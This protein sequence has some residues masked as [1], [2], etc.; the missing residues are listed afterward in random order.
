MRIL[1]IVNVGVEA[2]GAEKSVRIIAEGLRARGHEAYVLATDHMFDDSLPRIAD[3]LI[4]AIRGGAVRRLTGFF[5]NARAH[6]ETRRVLR[7]FRPDCVHLHTIGEFSPSVLAATRS[8]PRV[9]TVHGPEDWTLELLRWNLASAA[10]GGPLT[11]ADRARL[12]YL[13]FLQR[14]AYLLWLRRVEL[15]IAPSEYF[16]A[17]VRRD[18]GGVP[19]RVLANGIEPLATATRTAPVDVAP[20]DG[21]HVL[22]AGRLTRVKGVHVLVDAIGRLREHGVQARLTIVGDGDERDAL[23]ARAA[24]LVEQ[25]AVEFL[26]W[27]DQ[28]FVTGLMARAA[29]VVIPSLW[30]EN[31]PTVA[32]EALQAGRPLIASRVGGLPELVGEDNGGL[33]PA[34]DPAALAEMLAGVLGDAARLERLGAG[35]L[36][37]AAAY[38]VEPFIDRVIECYRELC[39]SGRRG[40]P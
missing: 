9:V 14:P 40:E 20:V 35:S 36:A 30:P 19:V 12:L 38:E 32:L 2:G 13:R 1:H 4:P 27:R 18:A 28:G 3:E 29:V 25:G 26:G 33:V 8:L 6:A 21:R 39:G 22:Y 16:A 10:G 17:A 23:Q 24:A 37:R 11:A 15:I 31:F 34:G 5:W 7:E